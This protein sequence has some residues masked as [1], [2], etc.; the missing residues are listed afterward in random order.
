MKTSIKNSE[1]EKEFD[2][3]K[4]FRA[5]KEKI[6]LEMVDMS[7]DQIKEYLKKNSAKLYQK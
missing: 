3:V 4:T 1:P 5:I 6:S 2:T 7:P